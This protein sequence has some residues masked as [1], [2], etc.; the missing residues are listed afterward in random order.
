LILERYLIREITKPMLFG[1]GLLV[2]V[3]AGYTSAVKLAQAA[4]G[5]LEPGMVIRLIALNTLIALEVLL[6]TALYLSIISSLGRLYRD[7]EVAALN[8]A[9][10]SE[11]GI[12]KSVVILSLVTAAVVAVISVYGR[13]WAYQQSYRIEAEAIAEFDINRLQSGQFFELQDNR[14][15]LYAEGVDRGRSQLTGVFMQ[16]DEPGKSRIIYAKTA[17]MPD[18]LPGEPRSVE[19]LDGYAYVLDQTGSKDTVLRFGALI[20]RLE[21]DAR[22]AS[23]K[24]KALPTAQLSLSDDP[25]EI[26]EFQWRLSTPLA[27]LLLAM[28]AVPLARSAPRESRH[29]SFIV[30]VLV[31]IG[32]F[33]LAG[34]AR[35]WV[36]QGTV[37]PWPGIWWVFG[38]AFA[39]WLLLMFRP[40][41]RR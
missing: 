21:E 25:K 31:Y 24:R 26:A 12:L 11:F 40:G 39:L 3:F 35:N 16:N 19:F 38:L 9:G 13:P 37:N 8:A 1:V 28:L 5:L 32:F 14:Y 41:V 4:E 29:T 20:M 15:V 36:E 2:L 34:I 6:P 30:A 22:T 33:N 18:T 10:F 17:F 7:S 27:T 23:R